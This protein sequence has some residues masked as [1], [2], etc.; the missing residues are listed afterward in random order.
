MRKVVQASFKGQ[1]AIFDRPAILPKLGS[2]KGTNCGVC[3]KQFSLFQLALY[4]TQY[5]MVVPPPEPFNPHGYNY[6]T[7]GFL[8]KHARPVLES[9]RECRHSAAAKAASSP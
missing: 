5:H 9:N 1:Y 8:P 4:L 6:T 2:I 3:H 7:D